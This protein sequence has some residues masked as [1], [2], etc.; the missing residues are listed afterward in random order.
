[1]TQQQKPHAEIKGLQ[2]S[3]D[4]TDLNSLG[5]EVTA[6]KIAVGLLFQKME[7]HHRTALLIE[8]RQ[9]NIKPLHDLANQLEQFKV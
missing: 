4:N 2:V 7:D 6:L 8:L 3:T 9:L 5:A 1:M